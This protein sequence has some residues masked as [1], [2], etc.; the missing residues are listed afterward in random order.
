MKSIEFAL[1]GGIAHTCSTSITVMGIGVLTSP[2]IKVDWA[3]LSA[4][5][6]Y[7][8]LIKTFEGCRTNIPMPADPKEFNKS[9]LMAFGLSNWKKFYENGSHCSIS[10]NLEKDQF[11]IT[12]KIYL[13]E[14]KSLY[15]IKDGVE[16]IPATASSEEVLATLKR[17]LD[18]IPRLTEEY[19]ER[20]SKSEDPLI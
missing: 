10:L 7:D 17:V 20:E 15:G 16:C 9:V 6:K 12:P 2:F 4:K 5:E 14:N 1:V 13:R 11:C 18:K 19:Y 3:N 8:I